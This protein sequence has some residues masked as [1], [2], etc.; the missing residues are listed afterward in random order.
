[1]GRVVDEDFDLKTLGF[2]P[3]DMEY[4]NGRVW[5]LKEIAGAF[6]IPYSILDTSETKKAT[7]ELADKWYA[8]NGVL[9]RITRIQEK[10]N[11]QLV[12]MYDNSDRLF[13]MYDNPIPEDKEMLLKEN[14][15]YVQAGIISVDEA[16]LNI[17]LSA[18]G[19]DFA[20][21]KSGGSVKETEKVITE[22]NEDDGDE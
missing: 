12:P 3:R 15:S 8:K 17:G 14:T 6:N 16:R 19:G 2:S 9:P 21:P 10:L 11:E 18:L 1:E 7:S 13:L 20:L 22:E 4:L 5:S